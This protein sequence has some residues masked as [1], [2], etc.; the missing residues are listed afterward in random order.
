MYSNRGAPVSYKV[1]LD[2]QKIAGENISFT[3]NNVSEVNKKTYNIND[4]SRKTIE[5]DVDAN[6]TPDLKI[7]SEK[8]GSIVRIKYIYVYGI[9]DEKKVS[10]LTMT[11]E[12]YTLAIG[13]SKLLYPKIEPDTA[14]NKKVTYK[15][16]D[17]S[18]VQVYSNGKIKGLKTG[19]ATIT[20]TTEDG[21]FTATSII[22]V[23]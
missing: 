14:V 7:N 10:R 11:P 21:G 17:N 19:V 13:K 22:T 18:I 2:V 16:S 9:F 4:N 20:A 3:M 5:F 12:K 1:K 23:E 15:S 8:N 6:D